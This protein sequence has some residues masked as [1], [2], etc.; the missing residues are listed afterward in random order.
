MLPDRWERLLGRISTAVHARGGLLLRQRDAELQ[1]VASDSVKRIVETWDAEGW[2][3]VNTRVSRLVEA[4]AVAGF[5][6]DADLHSPEELATLPIYKDF[7][8]PRGLAAGAGTLIDGA[9][10]DR[11]MLTIE[12]FASHAAAR[13]AVTELDMLRPHLARAAML[14]GQLRLQS[15]QVAVDVLDAVGVP[16]A[17]LDASHRLQAVNP[18]FTALI[19]PCIGDGQARMRL[20]DPTADGQLAAALDKLAES[21]EI[22][23]TETVV[24][25]VTGTGLKAAATVADL[26]TAG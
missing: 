2:N 22:A 23:A 24:V 18:R 15:L 20:L 5:V 1:R 4:P 17:T 26:T 12:G 10:G 16:A 13:A 3:A 19:G 7:L 11:L 8:E 25:L 21:G 6:S 9:G 14:S